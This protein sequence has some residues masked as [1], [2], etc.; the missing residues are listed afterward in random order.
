MST[1][2]QGVLIYVRHDANGEPVRSSAVCSAHYY[3]SRGPAG[4]SNALPYYGDKPLSCVACADGV[5]R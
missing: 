2:V 5:E 4:V 3:L 1:N